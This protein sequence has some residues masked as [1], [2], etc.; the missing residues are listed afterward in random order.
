MTKAPRFPK[1]LAKSAYE[2][3]RE[4]GKPIAGIK[5]SP[6]PCVEILFATPKADDADAALAAWQRGQGDG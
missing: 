2:F 5:I 1:T 6:G 3:A 4:T